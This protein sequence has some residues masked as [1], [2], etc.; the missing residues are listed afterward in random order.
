[1][2]KRSMHEDDEDSRVWKKL[3]MNTNIMGRKTMAKGSFEVQNMNWV[4]DKW[5]FGFSVWLKMIANRINISIYFI[6]HSFWYIMSNQRNDRLTLVSNRLV[7]QKRT[8]VNSNGIR[9]LLAVSS[10][11]TNII[12]TYHVV[13]LFFGNTHKNFIWQ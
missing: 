5:I 8:H 6:Y 11:M 1:M 12:Q 4:G 13:F 9:F 7:F 3:Y 10:S 2:A